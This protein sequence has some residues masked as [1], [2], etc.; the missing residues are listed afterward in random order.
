MVLTLDTEVKKKSQVANMNSLLSSQ[1][2]EE[3]LGTTKPCLDTRALVSGARASFGGTVFWAGRP[4]RL[5][6][7]YFTGKGG[8]H[9]AWELISPALA[10]CHQSGPKE[11][12]LLLCKNGSISGN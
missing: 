3:V 1:S 4:C 5:P 9:R 7:M 11:M 6:H 12:F 8:S 2:S 10:D